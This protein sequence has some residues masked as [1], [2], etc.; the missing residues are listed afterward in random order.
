MHKCSIS[1]SQNLLPFERS[2]SSRYGL[3][4]MRLRLALIRWSQKRSFR[5]AKGVILLSEYAR[6]RVCK[7]INLPIQKTRVI[8]HGV[9][10]RFNFAGTR[11][12]NRVNK[13]VYVSTI[14]VYKHQWQ[15]VKACVLLWDQGFDFNLDLV[16]GNYPPSLKKLLNVVQKYPQYAGKIQII[17]NLK[18]E[19]LPEVYQES[20]LFVYASTCETFGLTVLEA[21]ASGLPIACSE[22]SSM[23]EILSGCGLYFDPLDVKSIAGSIQKLL[24]NEPLRQE[25]GLAAAERAKQFT[26]QRS[27]HETFQFLSECAVS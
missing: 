14:D 20:D 24:K 9:H 3:S 10:T 26:W 6:D 11:N 4:L 2:E 18:Y 5:Q 8:S 23:K 1:M 15:V 22:K 12:Y 25:L 17:D 27:S 16:G 13:I 21:M 7:T 19:K